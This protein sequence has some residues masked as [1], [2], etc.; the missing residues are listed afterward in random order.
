[1][2]ISLY[3][4]KNGIKYPTFVEAINLIDSFVQE[5]SIKLPTYCHS[6]I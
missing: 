4:Q 5:H 2:N 6:I 1:M 3:F